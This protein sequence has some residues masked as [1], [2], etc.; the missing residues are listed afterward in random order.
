MESS[1]IF[2]CWSASLA[3]AE[4]RKKRIDKT[5]SAFNSR[6]WTGTIAGA[7]V[8]RH[9]SAK[10]RSEKKLMMTADVESCCAIFFARVNGGKSC[11]STQK[12]LI[13]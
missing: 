6:C 1:L 11:K 12:R 4:L 10:F 2:R 7:T 9:I 5:E 8:A 13:P 3:I